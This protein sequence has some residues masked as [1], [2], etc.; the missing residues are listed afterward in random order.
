VRFPL[1]LTRVAAVISL[2]ASLALTA[3][4]VAE[5][6]EIVTK[7]SET[8][9]RPVERPD[10]ERTDVRERPDR[11]TRDAP[12]R[13]PIEWRDS[14]AVGS[15]ETGSLVRGV[16]FPAAGRGFFTW[17]PIQRERPNRGWRRWGTDELVGTVLRVLRD[18]RDDHP[19][20]PRIGVGDLSRPR[21]GDFGPEYG[22]IGHATH[23]NGLDADI[24]YPRLDRR[25]RP[26]ERV[27]QV[28]LELSQELVDRFLAAGAETIYVG[29]NTPLTGPPE[30][31]V[32]AANHDNHVHVRIPNPG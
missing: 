19:A 10:A 20:A 26:P 31:V 21:G 11:R 17:D 22:F 16:K 14:V 5:P 32:P 8:R 3:L 1:R 15:P 29:P 4:V 23:Q 13:K 6:A 30:I 24:Y 2:L 18:F 28:D 25:E 27:E 12:S 7:G 9:A